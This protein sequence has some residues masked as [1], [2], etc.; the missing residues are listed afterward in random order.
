VSGG[1]HPLTVEMAGTLCALLGR[2]TVT[3]HVVRGLLAL[4]EI[5]TPW[6]IA[7]AYDRGS[8]GDTGAVTASVDDFRRLLD[9]RRRW[10]KTWQRMF[11]FARIEGID[12]GWRA[13]G[14]EENTGN[15]CNPKEP[16]HANIESVE[17]DLVPDKMQ[18]PD[19]AD[20]ARRMTEAFRAWIRGDRVYV[21][22]RIWRWLIRRGSRSD[23]PTVMGIAGRCLKAHDDRLSGRGRFS[24]RRLARIFGLSEASVKRSCKRLEKLGWIRRCGEFDEGGVYSEV[25]I[26]QRSINKHGGQVEVY[27]NWG[28]CEHDQY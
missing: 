20:S 16:V 23:I 1:F 27:L 13:H 10:R 19:L 18:P 25:D 14:N 5:A 22:R 26:K 11:D 8:V 21:P 12:Y 24:R 7:D 6:R 15:I 2:R 28:D 17:F 3:V 4:Y 9:D